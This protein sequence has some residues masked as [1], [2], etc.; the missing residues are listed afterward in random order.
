MSE[1]TI[2]GDGDA[3]GNGNDLVVFV[4]DNGLMLRQRAQS[5]PDECV[6]VV[7]IHLTHDQARE[8]RAL[9]GRVL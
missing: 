1:H 4:D 8:L 6:V 5:S 2:A 7:M 9:L 3:R